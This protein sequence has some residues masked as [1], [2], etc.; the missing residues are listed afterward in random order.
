M[1]IS[2]KPRFGL[3]SVALGLALCGALPSRAYAKV[4]VVYRFDT[5]PPSEIFSSGFAPRGGDTNLIRHALAWTEESAFI[6]TTASLEAA[7]N[8]ANTY[9]Q[10]DPDAPGY[11]YRIEA[12]D[13][14]Y[15]VTASLES[16]LEQERQRGFPPRFRAMELTLQNA[17][18]EYR[19]QQE[20]VSTVPI[21]PSLIAW[22]RPYQ[23]E[24][25]ADG[26]IAMREGAIQDNWNWAGVRNTFSNTGNYW[27]TWPDSA[28]SSP[29]SSCTEA[30][31]SLSI[32]AG[33]NCTDDLYGI[34][35]GGREDGDP[36]HQAL[37]PSSCPSSPK[38]KR[39]GNTPLCFPLAYRIVNLSKRMRIDSVIY[40]EVGD[41]E[42]WS[43]DKNDCR[44]PSDQCHE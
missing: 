20:Y 12:D 18:Q 33:M 14:F 36:I 24:V 28:S 35:E 3:L 32:A 40:S 31:G 23:G 2:A 19:W 27:V 7:E 44:L 21:P 16:F 38:E 15:E 13:S 8:F 34:A 30:I 1:S 26:S 9:V 10:A 43:W 17:I 39:S 41:G 4:S 37:L 29:V 11:I 42:S 25:F 6:A 22:A 5:R